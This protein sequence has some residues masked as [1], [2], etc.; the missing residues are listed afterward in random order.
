MDEIPLV[1][2]AVALIPDTGPLIV[3]PGEAPVPV[4]IKKF[5][6]NLLDAYRKRGKVIKVALTEHIPLC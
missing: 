6:K 5:H 1:F 2:D 3:L 4:T